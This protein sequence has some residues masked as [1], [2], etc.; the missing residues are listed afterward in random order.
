MY[1]VLHVHVHVCILLLDLVMNMFEN[2][3]KLAL[4]GPSPGYSPIDQGTFR[5]KVR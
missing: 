1:I 3:I 4:G 2:Y 5:P